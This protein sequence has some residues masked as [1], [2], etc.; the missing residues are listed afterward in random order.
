VFGLAINPT[1]HRL[2]YAVGDGQI[3]SIGLDR[4]G[5]FANDPRTEVDLPEGASAPPVSAIT[6]S[7]DG[8][9]IVAERNIIGAAYDYSPLPSSR[10]A[11]VWRFWPVKPFDRMQSRHFYA[12]AEEYGIGYPGESRNSA[13]GVALGYG[14]GGHGA[15]DLRDWSAGSWRNSDQPEQTRSCF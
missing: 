7:H 5:D 3:W 14:Y 15:I 6:F 10:V 8:A 4:N 9:M 11:H 13:G 1:D 12:A 2:Y